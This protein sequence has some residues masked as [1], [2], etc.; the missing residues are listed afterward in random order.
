MAEVVDP[1]FTKG[2]L[3]ALEDEAVL[4]KRAEDRP[5]MLQVFCLGVAEDENVVEEDQYAPAEKR[6]QHLVHEVLERRWR[7]DE[8]ERHH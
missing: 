1:A 2:A 4:P 3:G 8:A 7:V 5:D 6:P